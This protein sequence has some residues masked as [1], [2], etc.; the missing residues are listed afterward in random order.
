[1]NEN[2]IRLSLAASDAT[3]KLMEL[4]EAEAIGIDDHHD[5]C[6]RNVDADFDDRGAHEDVDRA[7]L[8]AIHRLFFFRRAHSAVH[9][10][11]AAIR[12]AALDRFESE[13]ERLEIE[14]LRLFDDRI[15]DVSLRAGVDFFVDEC[16]DALELCARSH[17][18]L[19]ALASRRKLVDDGEFEVAENR[20][21]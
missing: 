20:E 21:R 1:M 16:V 4:R 10:G 13:R 9:H 5:R 11:D 2:A 8:E 3:A 14:L 6:I 17:G 12:K 15:N 18:G 19:D 7:T